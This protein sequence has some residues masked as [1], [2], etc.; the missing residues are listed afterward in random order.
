MMKKGYLIAVDLDGTVITGFDNYDKKSFALLKELANEHK[1][2]IATGRP[3]RSSKYYYDLLGLNT[4]LIN[5]NGSLVHNPH[6]ALFPKYM[7]TIPKESLYDIIEQNRDILINLFCEIEDDI[8]LWKDEEVIRPY[9]HLDGGNLHVGEIKDILFADSNGAILISKKGS[10][11]KLQKFI[12]DNYRDILKIRFWSNEQ[13][14]ISEIYNPQATKGFGL[15]LIAKYYDIPQHKIIAIG[16]GH[17]D[18]ELL[19]TAGIAVAMG[20]SHPDLKETATIITEDVMN[21][22]VYHFLYHFFKK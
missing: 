19:Q 3:Y 20:N 22:G 11:A 16:D 12:E 17:N 2:V 7:I 5:Y 15:E 4:P 18:I 6:D 13:F 1:V 9:L 8:Y 14:V 10:E 21:N